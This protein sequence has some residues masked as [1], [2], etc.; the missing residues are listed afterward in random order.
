VLETGILPANL[1]AYLKEDTDLDMQ[2][3]RQFPV[4]YLCFGNFHCSAQATAT[5]INYLK[6]YSHKIEGRLVV[7]LKLVEV[8]T[9]K[10]VASEEGASEGSYKKMSNLSEVSIPT[11][12][13]DHLSQDAIAKVANSVT[14]LIPLESK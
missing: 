4:D 2:V 10:I 5:Y 14:A 6:R 13:F 12:F 3:L 9:G 7:H 8:K 1:S 11:K